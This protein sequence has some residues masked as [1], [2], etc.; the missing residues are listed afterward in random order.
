MPL[1]RK[2]AEGPREELQ[3]HPIDQRRC[4]GCWSSAPSGGNGQVSPWA[5]LHLDEGLRRCPH[6]LHVLS[7][8]MS[9]FIAPRKPLLY[10]TCKMGNSTPLSLKYIRSTNALMFQDAS[11]LWKRECLK[12]INK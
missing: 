8:T 10:P 11:I 4:L 1:S 3:Q 5:H 9:S 2:G 12:C 7:L 6:L